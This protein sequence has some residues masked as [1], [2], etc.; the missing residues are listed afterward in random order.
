MC[1]SARPLA[2]EPEEV[3][4]MDPVVATLQT[5]AV[6]INADA[7]PVDMR[8]RLQESFSCLLR[9]SA[10]LFIFLNYFKHSYGWKMN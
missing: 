6:L 8:Y 3:N 5:C 7:R 4:Y 9:K 10:T 2:T 1:P